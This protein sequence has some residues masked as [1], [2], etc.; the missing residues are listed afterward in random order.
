V[1][2]RSL[3]QGTGIPEVVDTRVTRVLTFAAVLGKLKVVSIK[4]A[5]SDPVGVS[6][7]SN[8]CFKEFTEMMAI[9]VIYLVFD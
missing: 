5:K 3:I 8:A 6:P 4:L 1:Y 2:P 7:D 9:Y